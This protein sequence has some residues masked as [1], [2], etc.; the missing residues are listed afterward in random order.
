MHVG[1]G[2]TG[3]RHTVRCRERVQTQRAQKVCPVA[4]VE[5]QP[6]FGVTLG[7]V[8]RLVEGDS[9]RDRG[10]PPT[11][12]AKGGAT[13]RVGAGATVVSYWLRLCRC[14]KGKKQHENGKFHNQRKVHN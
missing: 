6:R 4:S 8:K 9:S 1:H 3:P 10:R 14:T 13:P 7:S 5:P 12:A 11:G 2:P